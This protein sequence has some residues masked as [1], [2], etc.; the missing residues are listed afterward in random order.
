MRNLAL[1]TTGATTLLASPALAAGGLSPSLWNT[2]FVVLI[3]FLLFVGVLIYFKVPA[4]LTGQLDKRSD[5]IRAE[6]DEARALREEAQT[7]L[8]TFERK[9]AEVKDQAERIIAHAKDQA[10]IAAEVAKEDL[11]QSIKRRLA[12]ADDQIASA[13]AAAVRSIKDKA[14]QVAVA[15]AGDVVAKQMSAADADKLI[16]ASISEAGEKLH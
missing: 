10:K 16:E 3:S 2:N 12:G 7:V 13:E 9:Q 14:V 8:A 4:L 11:A 5:A 6:L 15:A 1:I